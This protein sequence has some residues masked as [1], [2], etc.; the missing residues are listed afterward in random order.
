KKR[1]EIQR[2][3]WLALRAGVRT[4]GLCAGGGPVGF[5]R[6]GLLLRFCSCRGSRRFVAVEA[7]SG[8]GG[9]LVVRGLV[10]EL[11]GLAVVV[12][13]AG[14]VEEPH[15]RDGVDGVMSTH[16]TGGRDENR[17]AVALRGFALQPAL[18]QV[19]IAARRV[20][21]EVRDLAD[22]LRRSEADGDGGVAAEDAQVRLMLGKVAV[23]RD[24]DR[25]EDRS[26]VIGPD[27]R[28]DG[29]KEGAEVGGGV[30]EVGGVGDRADAA[31]RAAGGNE[32]R[33][34]EV[35][36]ELDGE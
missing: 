24:G 27:E 15:T 33:A 11:E 8:V 16:A 3:M 7:G 30:G 10:L 14:E 20:R 1:W 23:R 28:A 13:G 32:D 5:V 36:I 21:L 26:V 6:C 29:A 17:G 25:V 18:G 2:E 31:P 9:G 35:K 4:S 19:A 34:D 12:A 22:T